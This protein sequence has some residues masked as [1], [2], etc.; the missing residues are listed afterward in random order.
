MILTADL[1]GD[2]G[3]KGTKSLAAAA[4]VQAALNAMASASPHW[5]ALDTS[6]PTELAPTTPA[7]AAAVLHVSPALAVA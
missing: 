3:S 6:M 7:A 4:I 5:G 1:D 2:D